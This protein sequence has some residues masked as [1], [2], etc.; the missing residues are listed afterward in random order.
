MSTLLLGMGRDGILPDEN[1]IRRTTFVV[2]PDAPPA[3]QTGPP[4]FNEVEV[5]SNPNLGLVNTQK[6]SDWHASE[7]SAPGWAGDVNENHQHADIINRQVSTSGTAAARESAGEFG[8]GTAAYAIGIEPTVGVNPPYG[9]D[10]F[11]THARDV[12]DGAGNYMSVAPG[13]D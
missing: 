8:H 3:E 7:K 6:A 12:Q 4:E 10:Y 9:N 11:T 1:V 2:T 13:S 5:D